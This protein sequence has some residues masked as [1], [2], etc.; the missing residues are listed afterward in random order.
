MKVLHVAFAGT[1]QHGV[2][3]KLGEQVRAMRAHGALVES[4]VVVDTRVGPAPIDAPYRLIDVP[5]AGFDV[6]SRAAAFDVCREVLRT[7]TP[8]VVY[9]R[10]PVYDAQLLHF[11]QDAPPVV[12]ELQTIYALEAAPEQAAEEGGWARRVLP[13][14]AGLVS[15][16]SQILEHELGRAP[17]PIPG[18]VLPNGADPLAIAFVSPHVAAERVHLLCV[19][20]VHHWHGLDRIIVGL[21]SAPHSHGMAL[22]VVGDGPAVPGLRALAQDAG[23]GD[24]VHFHGT[25]PTAKLQPWYA[26]AHVAIGCLAAHRK[27]L[28]EVSA[29]KHRE[30]ALA[31]LPLIFAGA[32]A[33][34]PAN[35]PWLRQLPADDSPILPSQLRSLALGW[36]AEA[37]RRQIRQ[38]ALVHLSWSAKIPSLL[39]FLEACAA[40]HYTAL[41]AA[42]PS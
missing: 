42:A 23:V 33:D 1:D 28:H 11:L 3:R 26:Q 15:V 38:W 10:Y 17:R 4:L 20:N 39:A 7:F 27:G 12:F 30:Y 36:V 40:G 41:H 9:M 6:S 2:H 13:R 37:R 16:T 14:T 32:D 19:A 31:G 18:L 29:L 5:G 22:H 35:L 24:H 25:I 21:A 8:D 34:F